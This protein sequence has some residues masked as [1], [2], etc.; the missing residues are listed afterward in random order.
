LLP[1][2]LTGLGGIVL[3]VASGALWFIQ[4]SG[5]LVQQNQL[6]DGHLIAEG[7]A[8]AVA[9]ELVRK[10]YGALEERLLQTAADPSVSSA[11]VIDTQGQ[12]LSHVLRRSVDTTARPAFDLQTVQPPRTEKMFEEIGPSLF[13]VWHVVAVGI[14]VG[15]VRVEMSAHSYAQDMDKIRREVWA[16]ASAV[17]VAG[18]LLLGAAIFRSSN[19]LYQRDVEVEK[20]QHFLEDKANYDALTNL[21][22]RSLLFDRLAQA[23]ARNVRSQHVLAVC[24]VDLDEFKPINDTYGHEAGDRVLIEIARRFQASVRGED[25]VARIGGDEFVVLLGEMESNKEAEL[26]VGRLLLS[27]SEPLI[28]EGN[29][30]ELQASIGYALFPEDSRDGDDLL[31][32]AD[33][34]MYQ[35]KRSGRNGIRKYYPPE[36]DDL[37]T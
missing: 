12:V 4:S 29:R 24:F 16:L 8:N 22:N 19:L 23:I 34:A 27:L 11:L 9:A 13:S 32:C 7:L 3:L 25:T 31:H 6:R 35:A 17:I 33:Q 21:P 36:P 28:F 20:Q 37:A 15:W 30:F 14:N 5:N 2:I 10:D 26:T 1:V 18:S